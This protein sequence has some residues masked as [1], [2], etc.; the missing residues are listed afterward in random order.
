[1]TRPVPAAAAARR[2]PTTAE[3]CPSGPTPVAGCVPLMCGTGAQA[4]CGKVGDGCGG[5]LDC[6]D[7][8]GGATCGGGGI[9]HVCGGDP[10]CAKTTCATGAGNYC[11]DV[12]DGCGG[13]VS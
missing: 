13:V 2:A 5:V 7:C 12:G 8:T 10:T 1:M 3:D 6:G 4:R 11:G 9:A